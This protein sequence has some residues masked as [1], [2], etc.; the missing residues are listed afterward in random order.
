MRGSDRS[1]GI[2]PVSWIVG[3]V[4]GDSHQS[5]VKDMGVTKQFI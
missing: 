5:A 1:Q 4:L 2:S 3:R